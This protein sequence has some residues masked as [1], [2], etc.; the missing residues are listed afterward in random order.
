MG[1]IDLVRTLYLPLLFV[2]DLVQIELLRSKSQNGKQMVQEGAL[3]ALA[4]VADSSQEQFG[5][6]YDAV[7]P[8]LEAILLNATDKSNRTLR[9]KSLQCISLV[10]MAVWKDKFRDDA[11]Q[12][13]LSYYGQL[14]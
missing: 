6:Y 13:C 2:V 11:K 12:L 1:L 7:V 3:T 4:S 14:N 9:A 8:H 5:K 10:G